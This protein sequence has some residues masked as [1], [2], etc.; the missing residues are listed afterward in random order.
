[1]KYGS[2]PEQNVTEHSPESTGEGRGSSCVGGKPER[3]QCHGREETGSLRVDSLM[4]EGTNCYVWWRRIGARW[5]E[6]KG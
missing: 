2:G 6:F 4:L 1:M 3:G 5:V